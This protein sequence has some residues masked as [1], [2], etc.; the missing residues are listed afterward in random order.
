MESEY[1]IFERTPEGFIL[2]RDAAYGREKAMIRL[3]ELAA[4]S[5]N[6]HFVFHVPSKSVVARANESDF[7]EVT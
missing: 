3:R 7:A 5:E 1:D 6:E 4:H 2:W